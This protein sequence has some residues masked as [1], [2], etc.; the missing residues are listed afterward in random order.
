MDILLKY[1]PE[2]ISAVQE[3]YKTAYIPVL[4][5]T[6]S[7]DIGTAGRA[8]KTRHRGYLKKPLK[9]EDLEV[10]VTAVLNKVID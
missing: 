2:G 10:A 7:D 1:A 6:A 3:I 8:N 9:N 5:L 4:Y